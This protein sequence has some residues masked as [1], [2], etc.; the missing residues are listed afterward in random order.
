MFR[1]EMVSGERI[2][3]TLIP[4]LVCTL[5]ALLSFG[6]ECKYARIRETSFFVRRKA[7]QRKPFLVVSKFLNKP[8]VIIALDI[9]L[10]NSSL[11]A[12]S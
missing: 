12:K 10:S 9:S 5:V 1:G 3:Q 2:K 8:R 7:L 4:H 6:L 11:L